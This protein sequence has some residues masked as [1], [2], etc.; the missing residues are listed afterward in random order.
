MDSF[1]A[2]K[3]YIIFYMDTIEIR[4]KCFSKIRELIDSQYIDIIVPKNITIQECFNEII[5]KHNKIKIELLE[6]SKYAINCKYTD[7]NTQLNEK[8]EIAIITPISGG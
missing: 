2:H 8:N 7:I 1:I 5:K 4:F 3:N 6:K